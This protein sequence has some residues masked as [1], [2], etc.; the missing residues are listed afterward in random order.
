MFVTG[1][2]GTHTLTA[3]DSSSVVVGT[4]TSP[5]FSGGTVSVS[6]ATN[7]IK[8]FTVE[9]SAGLFTLFDD[10]VWSCA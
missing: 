7:T 6:L 3:Y 9:D 4:D 2:I 8:Y 1:G 5:A 10:I